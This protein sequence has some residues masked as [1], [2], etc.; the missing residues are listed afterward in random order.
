[1][2][3]KELIEELSKYDQDLPVI[4]WD[5]YDDIQGTDIK[6]ELDTYWGDREARQGNKDGV[7]CVYL[8]A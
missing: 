6:I 7:P 3:V 4:V 5:C 8:S 2:T 1:M